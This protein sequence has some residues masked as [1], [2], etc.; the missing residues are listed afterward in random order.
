MA[1]SSNRKDQRNILNA[2]QDAYGYNDQRP[3]LI[4]ET[5]SNDSN[6]YEGRSPKRYNS[7]GGFGSQTPTLGW[8]NERDVRDPRD[9]RQRSPPREDYDYYGEK[10]GGPIFRNMQKGQSDYQKRTNNQ[11]WDDRD[12]YRRDNEIF[13]SRLRG[14]E[15]RRQETFDR[16]QNSPPRE[17][18]NRYYGRGGEGSPYRNKDQQRRQVEFDSNYREDKRERSPNSPIQNIPRKQPNDIKS[19]FQYRHKSEERFNQAEIEILRENYETYAKDGRLNKYSLLKLLSLED[20]DD[21]IIGNRIY[22]CI[23]QI[24]SKG[25]SF[26]NYVNYERYIQAMAILAR[27]SVQE[28]LEFIFNVFDPNGDGHVTWEEMNTVLGNMF[29]IL[30]ATKFE[31]HTLN[32]LNERVNVEI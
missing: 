17:D 31:H 16:K 4:T 6:Q 26:G 8:N 15:I 5:H 9:P 25:A 19:A 28:R 27:G 12:D 2:Q 32:L 23:K 10:E 30:R 20:F 29:K 13:P 11:L 14:E 1:R 21:S 7:R 22:N 3:I 18:V 24:S